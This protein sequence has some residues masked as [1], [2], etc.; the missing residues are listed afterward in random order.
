MR[1]RLQRDFQRVYA[2]KQYAADE[3]LVIN[4][5]ENHLPAGL[6]RLGL[7]VSRA[8]GNA[9]VRNRWKR[10][11]REVFRLTYAELPAGFDFV[12][13]PKRGASGGFAAIRASLPHLAQRVARRSRKTAP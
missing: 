5:C 3:T 11:I 1:L 7:S 12:V 10:W 13:R 4:G 2:A 8:V 9:A 6:T